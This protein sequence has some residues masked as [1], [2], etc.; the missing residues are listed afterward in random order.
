MSLSGR[1][2]CSF[3]E[4]FGVLCFLATSVLRFVLLPYYRRIQDILS[5]L[6]DII[7]PTS[8]A[9]STYLI[10]KESINEWKCE[11]YILVT[12]D[13]KIC[14]SVEIMDIKREKEGTKIFFSYTS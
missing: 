11:Y 7:E 5:F 2:K 8:F 9:L 3:F 13:A 4:K 12:S 10:G 14:I 1:K 6:T